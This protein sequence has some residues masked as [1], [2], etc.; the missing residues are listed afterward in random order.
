MLRLTFRGLEVVCL[1]LGVFTCACDGGAEPSVPLESDGAVRAVLA[2]PKVRFDPG[3]E[4]LLVWTGPSDARAVDL[5]SLTFAL[6][7]PV[8]ERLSLEVVAGGKIVISGTASEFSPN[9]VLPG[10][11]LVIG[12]I[13]VS[14]AALPLV[15][16]YE[17]FAVRPPDA[18]GG[19]DDYTLWV[20]AKN[21][22]LPGM[23]PQRQRLPVTTVFAGAALSPEPVAKALE[24]ARQVWRT[25][26]IEIVEDASIRLDQNVAERIGRLAI[27]PRLGTDT[28]AF[29]ELLRMSQVVPEGTLCIFIVED[30]NTTSGDGIWAL[31]GSVPVPYLNGTTR[32]GL[33]A[34]YAL[35]E[36]DSTYAGQV[37]AHEIGH[38]LGLFHTSEAPLLVA[39]T[40]APTP[41]HDQLDDT[42]SCP[43]SAD[44]D[45]D[46]RLSETEC[47]AF[48]AGNL[49]FW[50]VRRGATAITASQA[51]VA[52]RSMLVH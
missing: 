29:G 26:G 28:P 6:S 5:L 36:R 32:S 20:W 52:R 33:V 8:D 17:V 43:A 11:G 13:P 7:G 2:N 35:I 30:V 34:S 47:A 27:D 38:A 18:R 22:L 19:A 14:T 44:R 25:A 21:A 9:R 10:R 41:I 48:D 12:Q 24:R 16:P 3:V 45:G 37:L 1:V 50:G 23:L 15:P 42:A 39:G 49:M 40:E 4:R 31:S 51:D 46:R